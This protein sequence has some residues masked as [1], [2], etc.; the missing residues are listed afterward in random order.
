MA[1]KPR[2]TGVAVFVGCLLLGLTLFSSRPGEFLM[3]PSTTNKQVA[4]STSRSSLSSEKGTYYAGQK[5]EADKVALPCA[6]DTHTNPATRASPSQHRKNDGPRTPME[7]ITWVGNDWY[8]PD[9]S[10]Y[11]IYSPRQM[12][13]FFSRHKSVWVGDSTIRRA[14]LTLHLMMSMEDKDGDKHT[15]EVDELESHDAMNINKQ[16]ANGTIPHQEK[17]NDYEKD[18]FYP[19]QD[20]GIICRSVGGIN[21]NNSTISSMTYLTEGCFK[22]MTPF[23]IE[24]REIL[25]KQYDIVIISGGL[26]DAMSNC[27]EGG[28]IYWGEEQKRNTASERAT[29]FAKALVD[30]AQRPSKGHES[31]PPIVAL[32]TSAHHLRHG[33]QDE[34]Q[35]LNLQLLNL[36]HESN[37][38]PVDWG[39]A[40]LPR[41][42]EPVRI[43]GNNGY[44][45][46]S[47]ARV[48][49]LQMLMN[50]LVG[51]FEAR[52]QDPFA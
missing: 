39:S 43:L 16:E 44:H 17:C 6:S 30:V 8:F 33:Y 40:M 15:L 35:R 21:G 20:Y 2:R 26:Y 51:A 10:D 52:G 11:K 14:Y 5:N 9:N 46:G 48:L 37:I 12:R 1:R 41:S 50:K 3:L 36:T 38:L 29:A 25:Q 23:L 34:I 24:K 42:F 27:D 47:T 45:F 18:A 22:N 19:I 49:F 28:A 32:R 4:A 13:D 31:R 7:N